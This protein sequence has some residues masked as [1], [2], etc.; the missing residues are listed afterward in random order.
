[1]G[2]KELTM[3][4]KNETDSFEVEGLESIY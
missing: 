2:E 3:K 1:M 4:M